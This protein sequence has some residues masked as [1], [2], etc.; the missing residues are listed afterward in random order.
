M[1]T[2]YLPVL[3]LLPFLAVGREPAPVQTLSKAGAKPLAFIENKG[4]VVDQ[5][6]K[7]RDDIDA[8]MEGNGL[9]VFVGDGT[10]HYQWVVNS[11]DKIQNSE[12]LDQAS[13]IK[14]QTSSIETY[15]MDV[16]LV[17]ANK[18]AQVVRSEQHE[19]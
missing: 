2:R 3:L 4:Q 18:N 13:N 11:K 1:I 10:I 14:D 19:Y 5:N 16:E 6:G 12:S 9:I 15:R 7:H 8:K 17:G